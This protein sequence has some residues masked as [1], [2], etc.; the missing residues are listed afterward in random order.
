[1]LNRSETWQLSKVLNEE[2]FY[3]G[4]II[5]GGARKTKILER[6]KKNITSGRRIHFLTKLSSILVIYPVIFQLSRLLNSFSKRLDPIA[7]NSELFADGLAFSLY[8]FFIFMYI[9]FF[10]TMNIV[11]FMKGDLLEFLKPYPLTQKDLQRLTF[12]TLLR[13]NWVQI[14]I[15]LISTPIIALF[16]SHGKLIPYLFLDIPLTFDKTIYFL[17]L[18]ILNNLLSII[19]AVFTMIIFARFL[20]RKIYTPTGNPALGTIFTGLIIFM[21]LV[22]L[23]VAYM[24]LYFFQLFM[25]YSGFLDS[26]MINELNHIL[27]LLPFF[28]SGYLSSIFLMNFDSLIPNSLV[29]TSIIGLLVFL[30]I[31]LITIRKGYNKLRTVG[32]SGAEGDY[33]GEVSM[34]DV[35]IKTSLHPIFTFIKQSIKM[36]PRDFGGI[37]FLLMGLSVPLLFSL[38]I[39]GFVILTDFFSLDIFFLPIMLF[40][41]IAPFFFNK[42]LSS[43]EE[44]IDGV[45]STLPY[46]NSDHFRSRQIVICIVAQIPLALVLVLSMNNL[47]IQNMSS[48]VRIAFINIIAP[49]G[50][51]I[52]HSFFFGKINNRFTL[53]R[54]DIENSLAKYIALFGILYAMILGNIFFIEGLFVLVNLIFSIS[55]KDY[56]NLLMMIIILVNVISILIL[57]LISRE[58]FN[59]KNKFKD[60]SKN[61]FRFLTPAMVLSAGIALIAMVQVMILSIE[62]V[63]PQLIFG[64]DPIIANLTIML[65]SQIV[66]TVILAFII[67]PLL[68]DENTEF[69]AADGSNMVKTILTFCIGFLAVYLSSQILINMF[70]ILGLGLENSYS[71]ILLTKQQLNDPFNIIIH[72]AAVSIGAPMFEELLNRRTMIPILEKR[73]MSPVAAVFATSIVFALSHTIND[74]VNGNIAYTITHFWTVFL[75]GAT[76]GIAYILTRN[77]LYPI[78]IHGLVNLLSFGGNFVIILDNEI[79]LVN[80]RIFMFVITIIGLVFTVY[81]VLK[82]FKSPL[83]SWVSVIKKKSTTNVLPGLLGFITIFIGMILVITVYPIAISIYIS[84]LP[85]VIL[86]NIAFYGV[87]LIIPLW[88]ETKIAM[89]PAT[90]L[91]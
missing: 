80:Y 83:A 66:S 85:V 12:F 26:L 54:V 30:A 47:T 23:P 56:L 25:I 76:C 52:L 64:E 9:V 69:P 51:L 45:L 21:N 18:L 89:R 44:K 84:D 6:Y 42:S 22:I 8:N 60:E 16:L 40:S 74:L 19:L 10:G 90:R 59:S 55:Q 41:G 5:T 49:T 73:G 78:L 4:Q 50:F 1:L 48:I 61:V 32:F 68:R 88:L 14:T 58:M 75:I 3:Q 28:S 15:T 31:S 63:T 82:Y 57:E 17:F 39:L 7:L 53:F 71:A 37:S 20:A 81:V 65:V 24:F 70:S 34:T 46:S 29:F 62:I 11:I 86:I 87:V 2:C 67:I 79:L 35:V 36:I 77:V 38:N 13:M 33:S 27:S 72:F 91:I 43:A